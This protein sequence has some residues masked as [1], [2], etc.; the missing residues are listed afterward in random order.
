MKKILLILSLFILFSCDRSILR[1]QKETI[2][3]CFIDGTIDTLIV[4]K[5]SSSPTKIGFFKNSSY[6]Y[7][8]NNGEQFVIATHVKYFSILKQE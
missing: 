2:E 7:Y 6:M 5:I 3:I 8:W 1:P 4:N